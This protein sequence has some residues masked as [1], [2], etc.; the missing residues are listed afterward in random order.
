VK[1][2]SCTQREMS[3]AINGRQLIRSHNLSHTVLLKFAHLRTRLIAAGAQDLPIAGS[4]A[5][6]HNW[7]SRIQYSEIKPDM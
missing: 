6:I 3:G 2:N 5:R 4:T 1:E 7:L